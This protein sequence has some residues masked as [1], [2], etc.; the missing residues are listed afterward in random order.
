MPCLVLSAAD[1]ETRKITLGHPLLDDYLVFVAAR[2]RTSTW[3]AV[4]YDLKVFFEVVGKEPAVV[5]AADVFAFLSAQRAPRRGERVVRLEDGEAGL[6][7]RTIARR[8]SSVRGLYGYL[9]AR[10]DTGVRRNPVPASLAARRPGAR[11]GRGGRGRRAAGGAADPPRPGH[12]GC[13]GAGRAAPLR[14]ARIAAG[15][16]RRRRAAAV[17]GRGQGRPSAG[18][19]GFGAVLRRCGRLPG[20][21]TARSGRDQA[22]VRGAERRPPRRAA[23]GGR[24]G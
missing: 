9:C 18:G 14:S 4:A 12:G 19:A 21:R 10:E 3:L 7:A 22:G 5:S 1:D 16:P 24:A 8:L 2:A 13:D 17:R 23:V 11:R 15:G 20:I 6:A